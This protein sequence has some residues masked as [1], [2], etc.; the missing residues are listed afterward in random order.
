MLRYEE[1]G[2]A[3][4]DREAGARW[5]SPRLPSVTPERVLVCPGTQGALLAMLGTL[6]APGDVICAEALTYPGLLAAAAHLRLKV[7]PVPMDAQGL[8][9]DAFE[10]ICAQR[11]PKALYCNPTLHNPT[12][13]TLSAERR[14]QLVQIA[15]DH[16]VPIIEDDAYGALP[17]RPSPP[18]AALAPELVYHVAGLAKC[19]SPALRIAYLVTPEGRGTARL[20]GAIRA[21]ASMASPLTGAIATRWIEDG[22]A[23]AVLAAIRAETRARQEIAARILPP[24]FRRSDESF[25]LWMELSA[26]WTRGELAARLRSLGVGVVASDAFALGQPPEAVRLGLGAASTR[27][28][29]EQTLRLMADMLE[30]SPAMSTI[31]V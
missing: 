8:I 9:P 7:T 17:A 14:E 15:R 2:G 24:T 27:D 4:R 19:L 23:G 13:A 16:Q 1:P 22:T 12:T 29:L 21:T 26:P 3:I 30:Q 10:E 28:E 6:A 25:H 18:L 5:L 11:T 31:V 20:A